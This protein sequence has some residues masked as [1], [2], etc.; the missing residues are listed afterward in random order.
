MIRY[1]TG[2]AI[3]FYL[4]FLFCKFHRKAITRGNGNTAIIVWPLWRENVEKGNN[5]QRRVKRSVG[6]VT[7]GKNSREIL[8]DTGKPFG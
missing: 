4:I 2:T 8:C 7:I 3:H 1:R 6:L 5:E